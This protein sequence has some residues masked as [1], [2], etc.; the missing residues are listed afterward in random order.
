[1]AVVHQ[2][3]DERM[4]KDGLLELVR[5]VD[6]GTRQDLADIISDF[7]EIDLRLARIETKLAGE[8]L[9]DVFIGD[10]SPLTRA[11]N[12][13]VFL[14]D[15]WDDNGERSIVAAITPKRTDYRKASQYFKALKAKYPR[16]KKNQP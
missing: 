2:L 9:L 6:W 8:D 16:S 5:G 15:C 12:V 3:A 1:M 14:A 11:P 7:E 4:R 13:S 10:K